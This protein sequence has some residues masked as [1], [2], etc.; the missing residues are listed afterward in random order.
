MPLGH[1]REIQEFIIEQRDR[2]TES[3]KKSQGIVT[4]KF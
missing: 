3:I 1:V 4:R 2:E